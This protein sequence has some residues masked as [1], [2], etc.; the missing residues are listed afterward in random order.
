MTMKV[1]FKSNQPGPAQTISGAERPILELLWRKGPLAG[2]QVYQEIRRSKSLAYTTVL[3]LLGRMVKK[4]SV[5]R[6][7]VNGLYMFEAVLNR[8]DFEEQLA[9]AA[10]RGILEISPSLAVSA[11]VDVISGWDEGKL[12]EVMKIIEERRKVEGR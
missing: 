5:R 10:M 4:G 9:S 8:A 7:R 11:F 6:Q 12:D 3:T 2:R 1:V